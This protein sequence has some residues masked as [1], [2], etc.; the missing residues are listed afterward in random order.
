[1][2]TF[3]QRYNASEFEAIYVAASDRFQTATSQSDWV[4]FLVAVRQ[5]AGLVISATQ[6]SWR[7]DSGTS[8]TTV[9]AVYTTHFEKLTAVES[10]SWRVQDGKAFLLAYRIESPE[11][12]RN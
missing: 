7:V 10:F 5:K 1:M 9:A 4:T 2:E 12:V 8:G 6:D 11:L 3:H